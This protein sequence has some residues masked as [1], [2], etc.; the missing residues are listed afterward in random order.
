VGSD[1]RNEMKPLTHHISKTPHAQKPKTLRHQAHK[2]HSKSEGTLHPV[3]KNFVQMNASASLP[4]PVGL[5]SKMEKREH[6]SEAVPKLLIVS[7]RE[8]D[9]SDD[10]VYASNVKQM[11]QFIK[12]NQYAAVEN[13][14]KKG[15][16][17]ANAKD[18]NDGQTLLM[19]AAK[20]GQMNICKCLIRKGANPNGRDDN[21][22][23]PI[24]VAI[25]S[26]QW[27]IMEELISCGAK[28]MRHKCRFDFQ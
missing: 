17:S 27:D 3:R 10:E 5:L 20:H 16:V 23:T 8:G 2:G 25:E 4:K 11:Q 28:G 21:G 6:S 13:I 14:L 1:D 19:L 22:R 26:E 7:E 15:G 24:F 9:L 18:P 12:G